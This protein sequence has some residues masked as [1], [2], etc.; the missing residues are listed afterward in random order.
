MKKSFIEHIVEKKGFVII[1][2]ILLMLVGLVSYINIPKQN[3]PE[4]VLPVAAVTIVYPGASA[5]DM[6]QLATK[7]VEEMVMS[8]N[9]FDSCTSE[10]HENYSTVLVSLDMKLRQEEVDKSFDDLRLKAN[11]LKASLPAGVTSVSV[12]TDVMDTA[13]M[14]I[15]VTSDKASGDELYQRSSE[16]K[17]KLKLLGGVKKVDLYG[18][19]ISDVK[20]TVD[21]NKLNSLNLSMA[22]I[23]S[24]ISAQNSMIPAGTIEVGENTIK[25][26]SNGKYESI[27]EIKKCHRRHIRIQRYH[28]Q[29]IRYC[30]GGKKRTRQFKILL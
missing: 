20:V 23:S 30:E 19:Q 12:T 11:S 15:A 13:G 21:I 29:T 4:V 28:I 26:N 8:L 18:A 3:F 25:V 6:E 2:I 24:L 9:G 10:I 5:E 16:L 17:D 7:K 14:L 1:I 22:D 27:D